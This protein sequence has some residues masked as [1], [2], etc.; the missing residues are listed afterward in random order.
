MTATQVK[1]SINIQSKLNVLEQKI[2]TF[3]ARVV[4]LFLARTSAFPNAHHVIT[5]NFDYNQTGRDLYLLYIRQGNYFAL[6]D[7]FHDA[8]DVSDE[9]RQII[10]KK[11]PNF[12]YVDNEAVSNA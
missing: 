4:S 2:A 1:D 8:T 9:A 11:Y 10:T 6:M 3:D 7:I 5:C 12:F